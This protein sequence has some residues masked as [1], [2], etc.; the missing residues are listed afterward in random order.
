MMRTLG[1]LGRLTV[2]TLLLSPAGSV[3]AAWGSGYEPDRVDSTSL[4]VAAESQGTNQ[5]GETVSPCG[6]GQELVVDWSSLNPFTCRD[7]DTDSVSESSST[8]TG[9]SIEA[10]DT[11][12]AS[13]NGVTASSD[14]D[15]SSS[16][17]SSSTDSSSYTDALNED[18]AEDDEGDVCSSSSSSSSSD[19]GGDTSSGSSLDSY[20]IPVPDVGSGHWVE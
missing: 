4:V 14:G 12:G 20:D 3:W 6:E 16:S 19:S 13:D 8:S 7:A 9:S 1:T 11:D 18:D 5:A 10:S 17:S 15:T 2:F